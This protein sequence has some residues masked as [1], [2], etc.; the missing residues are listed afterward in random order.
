MMTFYD[1]LKNKFGDGRVLINE[2]LGKYT[3]LRLGGPADFFLK[4][5]Q[6]DD[7]FVAVGLAVENGVPYFIL[8]GGTNVLF[9]DKGFRGLVVKNEM[10]GIR[11]AGLKGDSLKGGGG[12]SLINTVFLEADSGA[13]VNRLVRYSLDQG[14]SG[15]EF[16]LGQPGTIGGAIWI[17][18]H[19]IVK[20]RFFGE[21]LTSAVVFK[22][23][24]GVRKET[25]EYF[26]FGYD[27]SVLQ[28]TGEIVLT[29]TFA[30]KRVSDKESIW[31][32][33]R[34]TMLYR[35]S[36][37][38]KGEF[39]AGC[40]FRNIKKS[41]AVRLATPDYTVS[42]GFLI[43]SLGLKGKRI[44]GATISGRH[45][46]FITHTGRATSADVLKL[47]DLVRQMVNDKFRLKLETEI[48]VIPEEKN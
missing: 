2:N 22:P 13:G 18:A 39:S 32:T 44:G 29:A 48:L 9:S 16:F 21:Q 25:R 20:K 15:L 41:D 36:T 47:I 6:Q 24:N 35:T 14:L 27:R 30:F 11:L 26:R 5:S 23:G 28:K 8:G 1:K 7:L 33:A 42:A 12:E 10:A 34:E 40:I 37:Q 17:N 4:A 31:A 3:S 38:P 46:N 45:A 19:N 43:D